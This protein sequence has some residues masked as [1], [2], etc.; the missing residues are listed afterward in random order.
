MESPE[1]CFETLSTGQ[2]YPVKETACF[3]KNNPGPLTLL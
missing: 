3:G 2:D 1:S